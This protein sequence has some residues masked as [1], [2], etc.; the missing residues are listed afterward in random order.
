MLRDITNFLNK[1]NNIVLLGLVII[2]VIYFMMKNRVNEGFRTDNKPLNFIIEE[3][4]NDGVDVSFT[5]PASNAET[6]PIKAYVFVIL[7]VD[8][9]STMS[10]KVERI[11]MNSEDIECQDNICSYKILLKDR[12]VKYSIGL[13]VE[14]ENT[15]SH[16]VRPQNLE[17]F[18]LGMSVGNQM[19]LFD[20][21]YKLQEMEKEKPVDSE[22]VEEVSTA[23]G[24]FDLI[25]RE[26]G[27][28][29]DNLFIKQHTGP[30][31]LKEL[32][33]QQLSQGILNVSV[34]T[35]DAL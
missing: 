23:N 10:Q 29:P 34:H 30:N 3:V 27:G 19:K 22:K 28:F 32:V 20:K 16:I 17:L 18:K 1:N 5:K 4:Y 35:Q 8:N 2:M 7:S 12:D 21:I 33:K 13:Y 31:S 14:Y 26:L 9:S 25:K 6:G 24:R 11:E 15:N